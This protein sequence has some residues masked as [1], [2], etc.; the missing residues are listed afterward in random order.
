M[1]GF[2][3]H[4]RSVRA[5]S[6]KDYEELA[7]ASGGQAIQVSKA[8]LPQAT[9]VILDT[10]TSA[11]VPLSIQLPVERGLSK[12]SLGSVLILIVLFILGDCCAASKEPWAGGNVP[13]HVG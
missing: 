12:F 13:L 8:Q 2:G 7:L 1:T 6:F 11:L 4:R 5:G 3:R 10:S 9:D